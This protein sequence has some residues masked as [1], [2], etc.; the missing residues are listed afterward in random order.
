MEVYGDGEDVAMARVA[1]GGQLKEENAHREN[2]TS[3]KDA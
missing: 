1:Y 2:A 3:I